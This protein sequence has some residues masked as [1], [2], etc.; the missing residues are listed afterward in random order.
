M[1]LQRHERLTAWLRSLRVITLVGS[2]NIG[3]PIRNRASGLFHLPYHGH[4][5]RIRRVLALTLYYGF[6]QYLPDNRFPGGLYCTYFRSFLCRQFMAS[7][8][9]HVQ[10]RPRAFLADGRF[11]R[12][13]DRSGIGPGCRIYGATIGYGV[14]IGPHCVFLK[15]N[16]VYEDPRTRISAQGMT[17]PMPP[18]VEDEAWIG[19]R[20]IVLPGRRI[21]KGA[22][23]GAGAV[24]TRDV[25]PYAIV[26][27]NPARVIGSRPGVLP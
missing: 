12:M 8:G 2:H 19:E 16:H 14:I 7:A 6:A 3:I 27:G 26:G 18:I 4:M 5:T 17:A 15:D 21:G 10:I 24:V 25:E 23:V 22:I 1:T 9:N 13:A 20:V 11:L